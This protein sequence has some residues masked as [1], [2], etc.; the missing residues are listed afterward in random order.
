MYTFQSKNLNGKAHLGDTDIDGN[1]KM[2]FK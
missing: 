2:D 1:I